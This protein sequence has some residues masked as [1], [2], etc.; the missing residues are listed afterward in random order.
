MPDIEISDGIF[1]ANPVIADINVVLVK[2]I[3]QIFI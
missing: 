3:D 2:M 1:F